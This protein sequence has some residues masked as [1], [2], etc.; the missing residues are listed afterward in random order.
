[1]PEKTH[2]ALRFLI[3]DNYLQTKTQNHAYI[4]SWDGA[5]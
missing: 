5:I 2:D 3:I 1:M 4:L